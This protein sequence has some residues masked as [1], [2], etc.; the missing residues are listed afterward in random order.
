M[1]PTPNSALSLRL[2]PEASQV[3]L[4]AMVVLII[5]VETSQGSLP[6]IILQGR[7]PVIFKGHPRKCLLG[8]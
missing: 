8:E 6:P 1:S 5:I 7:D 3:G 4:E 2:V